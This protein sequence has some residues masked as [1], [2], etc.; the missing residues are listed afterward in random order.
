M[1][2][3][4]CI[5]NYGS[6]NVK[7]VY[8]I[9][10]YLGYDVVVSN[11]DKDIDNASHLI[12]PGV[13]SYGSAIKKIYQK[14]NID[15]LEANVLQKGKPFLGIC[16]GMQVL[17][18]YG[19]EFEKTKGLGWIPGETKYLDSKDKVLPH[20]GWNEIQIVLE[21]KLTQECQG[22]EFY[23][24]HSYTNQNCSESFALA[25]AEYGTSFNAVIGR[26]N[27]FGVQFHP[28][29]SQNSG[30]KLFKNFVDKIC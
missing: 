7:S 4:V 13:G 29:K 22:K 30:I 2:K 19:F 8:N 27:I 5:L 3:K 11:L 24:V 18:E 1:K 10:Y 12:L 26:E 15:V 25:K 17:S 14:I 21:N 23:F 16:V 6:G 28:E 9:I 20:I